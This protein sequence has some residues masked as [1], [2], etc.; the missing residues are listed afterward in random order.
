MPDSLTHSAAPPR[1][2]WPIAALALPMFGEQLVHFGIGLVDTY[3]AGLISKEATAAVGTGAYFGWFV[4]MIFLLVSTGVAALVSRSIGAKDWTTARVV[5]NHGVMLGA[6]LGVL[7]SGGIWLA[8][9][10]IAGQL[11]VTQGAADTLALFLRIDSLSYWIFSGLLV[12][13]AALR[14]AG[15]TRS[16]LRIIAVVATLNALVA[17]MLVYLGFGVRGIAWATMGARTLGGI[18]MLA[19]LLRG[20]AGLQLTADVLRPQAELLTRLF[21]IG[22]PGGLEALVN[23][24]VQVLFMKIVA[25]SGTGEHGTANYAPHMIGIRIE[26]LS[27]LLATAWMTASASLVGQALGAGRSRDAVRIGHLAAGQAA[28]LCGIIGAAIFFFAEGLYAQMTGDPLVQK[29]GAATIRYL[30]LV[31]PILGAAIVYVGTLRGVGDTRTTMWLALGCGTLV[32]VPVA[33]LCGITLGGGLLG[34]W[35][36]M[37]SDN[38]A[39][40]ALGFARYR[41]GAW[42]RL[43]V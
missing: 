40:F 36:G 37:F 23:I 6:G 2:A 21:R 25:H 28:V 12:G 35:I 17:A 10:W 34:V 8:A 39:R 41:A 38:L 27:T 11:S 4:N 42:V 5:L 26:T 31:E 29:V 22:V 18:A 15:D 33:Y 43:R 24:A 7:L 32:R 9:P 20:R 16:P 13:G 14:A 3:L 1:W 30:G 19:M